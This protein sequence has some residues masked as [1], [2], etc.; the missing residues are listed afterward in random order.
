MSD[1]KCMPSVYFQDLITFIE[2][3]TTTPDPVQ[4]SSRGGH[5]VQ[6]RTRAYSKRGFKTKRHVR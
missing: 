2:E 4:S 1:E 3:P 6:G 5:Q